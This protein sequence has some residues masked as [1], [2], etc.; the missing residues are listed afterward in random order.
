M[1]WAGGAAA[2]LLIWQHMLNSAG[3]QCRG[4]CEEFT[5]WCCRASLWQQQLLQHGAELDIRLL[6][7]SCRAVVSLV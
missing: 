7:C 6:L 1:V 3:E 4:S 2:A 5:S